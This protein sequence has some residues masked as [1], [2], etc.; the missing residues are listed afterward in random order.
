[1]VTGVN[2]AKK[3]CEQWWLTGI[4]LPADLYDDGYNKVDGLDL[5]VFVDYWLCYCPAGWPLK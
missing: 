3:G 4:G 5:Q 2:V 1:M